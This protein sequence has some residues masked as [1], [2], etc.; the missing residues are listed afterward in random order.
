MTTKRKKSFIYMTT[1]RQKKSFIY[2]TTK[3]QNKVLALFCKR[4]LKQ[5]K[6]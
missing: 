4:Y 3:R 5:K 2:M 6:S 1:K